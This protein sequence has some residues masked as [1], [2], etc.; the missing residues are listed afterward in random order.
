MR[1]GPAGDGAAGVAA[2]VGAA[3]D[4]AAGAP[5][6]TVAATAVAIASGERVDGRAGSPGKPGKQALSS[7]V[8]IKA[9]KMVDVFRIEILLPG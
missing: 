4:G 3:T 5:A 8:A 6:L 7:S 2:T 1:S 9:A